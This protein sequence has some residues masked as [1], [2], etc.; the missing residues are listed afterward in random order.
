MGG[1][2]GEAVEGRKA[3]VAEVNGYKAPLNGTIRCVSLAQQ[4]FVFSLRQIKQF[5][6]RVLE[7][8]GVCE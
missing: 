1:R 7:D 5:D 8:S 6:S 3:A 4:G 2:V